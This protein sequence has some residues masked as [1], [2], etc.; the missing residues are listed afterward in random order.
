MHLVLQKNFLKKVIKLITL[1]VLFYHSY[2]LANHLPSSIATGLMIEESQSKISSFLHWIYI[3]FNLFSRAEK[4]KS[5]KEKTKQENGETQK[6]T[7]HKRMK[8]SN[9]IYNME[10]ECI[11][12]EIIKLNR[13]K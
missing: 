8:K 3:K 6:K 4:K 11:N 10:I 9:C 1:M 12:Y 13:L 7:K 5:K 2:V